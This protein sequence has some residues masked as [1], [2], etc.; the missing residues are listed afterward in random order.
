[1][2]TQEEKIRDFLEC[3]DIID[4]KNADYFLF[5]RPEKSEGERDRLLNHC[6]FEMQGD[7]AVFGFYPGS[8]VPLRI[9]KQCYAKFA[10]FFPD[11]GIAGRLFD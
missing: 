7:K 1:M 2:P 3:L 4:L 5:E 6:R 10:H 8:A 11:G 9:R